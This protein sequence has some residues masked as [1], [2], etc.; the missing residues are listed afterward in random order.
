MPPLSP[1]RTLLQG[2]PSAAK[3]WSSPQP[4]DYLSEIS[5]LEAEGPHTPDLGGISLSRRYAQAAQDLRPSIPFTCNWLNPEDIKF[6]GERPIGAGGFANFWE[7][8]YN[9]RKVVLKSYRCYISFDVAQVVAVCWLQPVP[10]G[11][12]LT[13][14]HRGFTTRFMCTASFTNMWM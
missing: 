14:S 9:G 2:E 4:F 13:S 5:Q 6:L 3:E 7:V 1:F 10:S 12:L 8:T 11:T